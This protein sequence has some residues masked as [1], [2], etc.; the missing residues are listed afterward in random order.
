MGLFSSSKSSS[1]S[2]SVGTDF[3]PDSIIDAVDSQ[4]IETDV[5]ISGVTGRSA[6][7]SSG[8]IALGD[9]EGAQVVGVDGFGLFGGSELSI[10][11]SVNVT[12]DLNLDQS[13][14]LIDPRAFDLSETALGFGADALEFANANAALLE[15]GLTRFTDA[16]ATA[17]AQF[18][19]AFAGSTAP[20]TVSV[21]PPSVSVSEHTSEVNGM[22]NKKLLI[23]GGAAA[24]V[25]TYIL[26]KG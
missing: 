20:I 11:E 18:S 16:S 21:A 4:V 24:L 22:D 8:G 6:A 14:N 3:T 26:S 10:D 2:L 19:D 25:I 7:A 23:I 5:S 13:T 1:S 17:A 15:R 12:G 9:S